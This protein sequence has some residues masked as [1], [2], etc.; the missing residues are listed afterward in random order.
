MRCTWSWQWAA[1]LG[2]VGA[3]GLVPVRADEPETRNGGTHACASNQ[4]VSHM[5]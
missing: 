1:I 5:P 4:R 3:T 2:V